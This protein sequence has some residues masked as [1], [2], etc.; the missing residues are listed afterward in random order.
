MLLLYR[1]YVSLV[2]SN[3][4]QTGD[5][6]VSYFCFSASPSCSDGDVRLVGGNS[7]AEG[8]VE[9]CV[10]GHYGYLCVSGFTSTFNRRRIGTVV[11][12]DLGFDPAGNY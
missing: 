7:S 5:H 1:V 3:L 8:I 2:F 9:I 4:E 6:F 10:G 12:T 11:C